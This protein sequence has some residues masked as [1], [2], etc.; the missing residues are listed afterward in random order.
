MLELHVHSRES[1]T[2][3]GESLRRRVTQALD[4]KLNLFPFAS[5]LF[6]QPVVTNTTILRIF[7]DIHTSEKVNS[8][9]SPKYFSPHGASKNHSSPTVDTHS[10]PLALTPSPKMAGW[11]TTEDAALLLALVQSMAP[12]GPSKHQFDAALKLFGDNSK[13]TIGAVT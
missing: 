12:N 3:R 4:Q 8:K 9:S 11:T 7:I 6:P 5:F 1:T 13:W 10:Q 2:S